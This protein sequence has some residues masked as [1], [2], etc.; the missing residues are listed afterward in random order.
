MRDKQ[1]I[2]KAYKELSREEKAAFDD[3]FWSPHAIG[4][5]ALVSLCE[6]KETSMEKEEASYSSNR[7]E[8]AV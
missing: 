4:K 2:M 1:V 6:S 5:T 3:L 8:R 7:K